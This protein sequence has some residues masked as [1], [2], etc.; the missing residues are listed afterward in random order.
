MRKPN[1]GRPALSALEIHAF[2]RELAVGSVVLAGEVVLTERD[3][4]GVDERCLSCREILRVFQILEIVHN[5]IPR[6]V[7]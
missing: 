6:F 5:G 7:F 2:Q 1:Q 4:D 3:V